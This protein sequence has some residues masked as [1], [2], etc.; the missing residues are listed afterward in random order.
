MKNGFTLG[1][2]IRDDKNRLPLGGKLSA[3]LTDEGFVNF[4]Y[5][6]YFYPSSVTASR[7]TFPRGGR[8]L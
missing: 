8:L 6:R 1:G 4:I 5:K 7:D 3:E 2:A